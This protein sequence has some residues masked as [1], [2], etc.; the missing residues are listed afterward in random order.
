MTGPT[1]EQIARAIH[2]AGCCDI[3]DLRREMAA[4][5][6]VQALLPPHRHEPVYSR[7]VCDCHGKQEVH[8]RTC[9]ADL[10][11]GHAK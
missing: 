2:G 5:R 6:R 4:A 7:S 1:V 10:T 3:E 11:T 9:G 8:C